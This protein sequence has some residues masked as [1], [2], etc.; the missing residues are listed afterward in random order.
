MSS[1]ATPAKRS[2]FSQTVDRIL[3]LFPARSEEY[4]LGI[5]GF[6]RAS[7]DGLKKQLAWAAVLLIISFGAFFALY[8]LLR[9]FVP[10]VRAQ[11]A[12][13][14]LE[15]YQKTILISFMV[16]FSLVN[17]LLEEFFWRLFFTYTWARESLIRRAV[18]TFFYALYHLFV[19][20]IFVPLWM[21]F[22]GLICVFFAGIAFAIL[23]RHLG[24][25]PSVA[26]HV[27]ADA[28]IMIILGRPSV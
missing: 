4:A 14:G 19:L 9:D 3:T 26:V 5:K 13:F 12:D 7:N 23:H 6:L 10:D 16:Y 21:A 27:A 18:V 20:L 17:P 24:W 1:V 15:Q 25:L 8:A 22:V 11:A 28:V 2:C